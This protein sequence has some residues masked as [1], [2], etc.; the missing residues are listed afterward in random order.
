[1]GVPTESPELIGRDAELAVVTRWLDLVAGGPAGL[2]V[3]GEPGIG[4]TSVWS[5]AVG[6]AEQQGARVLIARP[7][8]AELALGYAALGDL[9]Q[10]VADQVIPELPPVQGAALSAAL[11]LATDTEPGN[12]LLVGRATLAALRILAAESTLLVAIDDVQW[13]DSASA[14][15]LAFA[16]RR[17]DQAPIGFALTLRQPHQDPMQLETALAD[18]CLRVK[19]AG[20]SLGATGHLLRT[21]IESTMPRRRLLKIHERAAGNPF[22]ALEMG[23]ATPDDDALPGALADLVDRRLAAAHAGRP[24]IELLAVHGPTPVSAFPDPDALDAAVVHGVLVERDG[25]VRF[26]HPL[27]AAGAYARIPP[28]RRRELHRAAAAAADSVEQRARH[29]ALATTDADPQVALVLDEA[30]RSAKARGAPEAAAELSAHA[31]RLTPPDDAA[32]RDRRAVDEAEYLFLADDQ[33]GGRELVDIVLSGDVGGAVRVRALFLAA[34]TTLD[35]REAVSTLESAVAEPHDDATLAARTLAQLAWQRGAWLGEVEPA[36]EEALAAVA[37]AESVG[38]PAT[39]VSALTTA[40]L[41]L[42]L[43]DRPGAAQY[44]ERAL[45]ITDRVPFAVGDRMPRVAYAVERAWRGDFET[46]QSLLAEAR[47]AADE[48]G[49]EWVL[50]R[51]NEF[52]ADVAIRRGRWDEAADL[53]DAALTDAVGYWRARTL[54]LRAILRARRGDE[55]A[56]HDAEEIRASPAAATDPLMA[57]AA[58]FAIG[59]L[60]H[61]EGRT[62]QAAERVAR[63]MGMGVLAG[64]RTAEFAVHIPEVVGILVEAGR[65]DDA[66]SLGRALA[67]RT[68]QLAPWSEAASSLCLGL[69]AHAAGRLD[70]ARER[71]DVA[72]EGFTRIDAPWDLACTLRAEASLLRRMGHRRDAGAVLERAIAIFDRLGAGPAATRARDELRRARPRRRDD[73]S[74]TAAESRVASLAVQGMTNR[75]IAAQQFTT[76]ATVEAHLTRIY[77]KLGL[78]SRTDLARRVSDGTLSLSSDQD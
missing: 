8:E 37:R 14:R 47:R 78:R 16:A 35:P 70:E 52:E 38:D 21:R 26:S 76:V 55:R 41:V 17:A 6:M 22:I 31:R 33:A 28:A 58:D 64:S 73:D 72:R 63:L 48:Q 24:A 54:V 9:L 10:E 61:A 74:L 1:M 42:S 50:M 25:V 67:R 66:E 56:E 71:F 39:L 13:L 18:R 51:L 65:L 27:L 19:L 40:G 34:L 60:D 43:S 77:S 23:R 45:S 49:N 68:V 4:K 2:V 32:S 69:V 29:L 75:E 12:P 53:L 20:L 3:V 7:V 46:A 59:L 36:I 15:A 30:A 5:A 57:A 44:F 62:A 11:A